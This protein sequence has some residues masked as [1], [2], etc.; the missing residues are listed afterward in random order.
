MYFFLN[1]FLKSCTGNV[2]FLYLQKK[3]HYIIRAATNSF[4][5]YR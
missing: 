5:L 2:E 4:F 1:H 3:V